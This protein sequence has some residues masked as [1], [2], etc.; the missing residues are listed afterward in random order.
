MRGWFLL[1]LALTGCAT[2]TGPLGAGAGF[3]GGSPDAAAVDA[4]ALLADAGDLA[5]D[6]GF[7]DAG[8]SDAGPFGAP[9]GAPCAAREDC[10]SAAS[11][12]AD[13]EPQACNLEVGW[14]GGYCVDYCTLPTEPL[15]PPR[16]PQAEC[17]EGAVCLTRQR[18][19]G[20][21]PVET[22]GICVKGCTT[23]ADCRVDEGYFCRHRF[24]RDG[25]DLPFEDG[26]CAPAVCA[27]RGCPISYRCGC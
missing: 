25:A 24:W 16:L 23:D 13:E 1:A 4:G 18:I 3:D 7:P 8:F 11:P 6:A 19:P 21:D 27:S 2:D 14:A 15:T 5:P 12:F 10:Q 17:P 9:V 20:H 26:Y 22:R